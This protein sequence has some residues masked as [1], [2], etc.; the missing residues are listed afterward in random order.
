MEHLSAYDPRTY[1][2]MSSAELRR[3]YVVDGLFQ[4]SRIVL[5]HWETDRT[6]LGGAMPQGASLPLVVPPELKAAYFNERRELG[7]INI[8]GVGTVLVDGRRF[9]L[10]QFDCL[11]VGRGVRCGP[12]AWPSASAPGPRSRG[13][14]STRGARPC[15]THSAIRSITGP[16][17][18]R[19]ARLASTR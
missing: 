12:T 14:N 15:R 6:V 4:P 13:K 9:P 8:G 16:I 5:R 1:G 7:I 18:S 10:G 17:L 2:R 11:Y 3:A 19:S